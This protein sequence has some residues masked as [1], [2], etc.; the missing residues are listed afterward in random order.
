[1][2]NVVLVCNAGMSTSLLAARMREAGGGEYTVNA[3]SEQ[4]YSKHLDGVDIILVG[5]QVRYL[6]GSI[7]EKTGNKIPVEGIDPIAYGRMDAAKI[8]KQVESIL[9]K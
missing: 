7:K 4:E 1:M 8:I 9:K 3:Y 2:T 5:P 6:L